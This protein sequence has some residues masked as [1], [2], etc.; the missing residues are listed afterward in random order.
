VNRTGRNEPIGVA[1]HIYMETTQGISLLGSL[2]LK[3][4]KTVMFLFL[5]FM[6]FLLQNLRTGEWNR[7][8]GGMERWLEPVGGERW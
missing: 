8:C 7:F 2:Y 5:S 4:A 3:L 1:I 6:F